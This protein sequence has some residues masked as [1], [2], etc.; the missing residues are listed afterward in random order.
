[1]KTCALCR[2]QFESDS[3]AVLY[4]SRYG[5]PQVLCASC[6]ALIDT[7]TAEEDSAEKEAARLQIAEAATHLKD[8][9]A[10]AALRDVLDGVTSAEET[11]ADQEAE[12]LWEE[13][14]DDGEEEEEQTEKKKEGF[15]DYLPLLL[16]GGLFVA[17]IVYFFFFR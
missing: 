11:P 4:L 2:N 17:F 15:L 5:T 1:M 3:P 13:T 12:A 14:K 7:A 16:A 9:G 6:E 10:I 8:H